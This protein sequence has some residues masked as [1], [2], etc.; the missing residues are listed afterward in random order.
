VKR[1]VKILFA[2][3]GIGAVAY[4]AL[5]I[6]LLIEADYD[7]FDKFEVIA[8]ESDLTAKRHAVSYRYEHADSSNTVFAIWIL[9]DAPK[10]GSTS[11]VR[12]HRQPAL[13][14]IDSTDIKSAHFLNGRL[15]VVVPSA[16]EVRKEVSACYFAYDQI[17]LVCI[18]PN[19]V[20]AIVK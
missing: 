2:I 3:I 18:N 14:S 16:V 11:P 10:I 4:I 1:I 9:P 6:T 19:E 17:H 15:T 5:A 8:I 13:V 20:D 7:P 12:G